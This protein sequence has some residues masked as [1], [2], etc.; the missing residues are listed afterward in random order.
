MCL[1]MFYWYAE[2]VLGEQEGED[3]AAEGTDSWERRHPPRLPSSTGKT[4]T[5]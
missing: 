1:V 3:G 5:S 2:V 4:T